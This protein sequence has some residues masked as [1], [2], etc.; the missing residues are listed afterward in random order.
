MSIVALSKCDTY[1]QSE[2]DDA[3]CN[4]L[5]LLGGLDQII[6]PGQRVLLKV[7]TVAGIHPDRAATTHP[8]LVAAIIKEVKKA[9]GIPC[10]GDSPG[11][12]AGKVETVM[13]T[14]G[15]KEV[16]ESLGAEIVNFEKSGSLAFDSPSGQLKE[17]L[18]IAKAVLA[19]DVIINLPKLKTHNVLLYTGAIKNMFGSVPGF[20]K[21]RYHLYAPKP[22]QLAS[23]MVDI[24]QITKPRLSIMDAVVGMDGPGPQSGN[25]YHLGILAA[26]LDAVALDAVCAYLIGKDP[27]SIETTRIAHERGIGIGDLNRIEVLGCDL[28]EAKVDDFDFKQ[29]TTAL[30]LASQIP[31]LL[32]AMVQPFAS[33]I[34]IEPIIN[35]PACT[36]CLVCH[37]ICPTQAISENLKIDYNKCIMCFCCHELCSYKA[38]NLKRNWLAKLL[39]IGH[40]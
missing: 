27:L 26:S 18:Q 31:S 25:P 28:N 30:R 17:K 4:C 12:P 15:L 19:A 16:A 34:R 33:R 7:N 22:H 37:K 38:I 36:K 5:S 23:V 35:R 1:H 8:A 29:A 24:F 32:Q 9:G 20:H 14:T 11:V 10:V 3:L 21:S 2:V 6:K 13:E 39:S 40:D